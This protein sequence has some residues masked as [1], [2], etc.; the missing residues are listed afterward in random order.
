MPHA[1]TLIRDKII[2][3]LDVFPVLSPSS[4][5]VVIGPHIPSSQWRGVLEALLRDGTVCQE[6]IVTPTPYGQHRSY[7][8]LF[9][10]HNSPRLKEAGLM[11]PTFITDG[12]N[13]ATS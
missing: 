6:S 13:D 9:L 1:D 5:H 10:A 4:L 7:T 12:G 3:A 8:R 2:H 11:T